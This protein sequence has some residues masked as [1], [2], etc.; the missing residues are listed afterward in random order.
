MKILRKFKVNSLTS[1][2]LSLLSLFLHSLHSSAEQSRARCCAAAPPAPAAL[3]P[4]RCCLAAPRHHHPTRACTPALAAPPARRR[5][6]ASP[7]G[8]AR[9]P[10]PRPSPPP[11]PC[12]PL[13]AEAELGPCTRAPR[14]KLSPCPGT[15]LPSSMAASPLSRRGALLFTPSQLQLTPGTGSPP[16]TEAHRPVP[17]RPRPPEHLL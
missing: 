8:A 2:F 10:C 15:P 17:A 6:A 11:S 7:L 9:P 1:L 16:S 12:S 14:A 3:L 5:A 4:P 13:K